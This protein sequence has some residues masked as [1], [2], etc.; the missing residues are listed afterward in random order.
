MLCITIDLACL[1]AEKNMINCIYSGS[2][3]VEEC[4]FEEKVDVYS[5]IRLSTGVDKCSWR[6]S[7]Q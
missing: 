1:R 3:N 5:A 6:W 7:S 2:A 4:S